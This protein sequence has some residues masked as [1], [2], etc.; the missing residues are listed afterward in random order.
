[1]TP[2]LPLRVN[3]VVTNV[4]HL[5]KINCNL[6]YSEIIIRTNV[7]ERKNYILRAPKFLSVKYG[8]NGILYKGIE[9]YNKF[10]NM[11]PAVFSKSIA[12]VRKHVKTIAMDVV[13]F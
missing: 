12:T 1:M 6:V 2:V 7:F 11:D 5:F 3:I 8:S 13:L 10:C 4:L 9:F